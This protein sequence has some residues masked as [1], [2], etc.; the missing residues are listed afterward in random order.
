MSFLLFHYSRGKSGIEKI[1][2]CVIV[3]VRKGTR[4]KADASRMGL[5]LFRAPPIL[6][7]R[8][9]R[10]FYF[11]LLFPSFEEFQKHDEKASEG[12]Q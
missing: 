8:Q 9:D 12:Y 4:S 7:D 2:Y 3:V 6:C 5:M 11:F 10:H 1:F